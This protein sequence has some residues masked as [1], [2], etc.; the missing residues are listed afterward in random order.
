MHV[1]V[2]WGK[3]G[4]NIMAQVLRVAPMLAAPGGGGL[5]FEKDLRSQEPPRAAATT[6]LAWQS[7][8]S[9]AIVTASY[10]P[11]EHRGLEGGSWQQ[12]SSH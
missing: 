2:C 3:V 1:S 5:F 11:L 12:G 6:A 10:L 9:F 7:G 8:E 4:S